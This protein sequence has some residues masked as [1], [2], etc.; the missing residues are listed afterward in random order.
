MRRGRRSQLLM[1]S[2]WLETFAAGL[3]GIKAQGLVFVSIKRSF[4]LAVL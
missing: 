3:E 4:L 2:E 1:L